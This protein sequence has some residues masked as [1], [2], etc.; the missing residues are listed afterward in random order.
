MHARKASR[1]LAHIGNTE[2]SATVISAKVIWRQPQSSWSALSAWYCHA[3]DWVHRVKWGALTCI[4]MPPSSTKSKSIFKL[5]QLRRGQTLC[6]RALWQTL[7]GNVKGQS[8]ATG[9][10]KFIP[11]QEQKAREEGQTIEKAKET[12]SIYAMDQ[13]TVL[14]GGVLSLYTV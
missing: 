12:L 10:R 13:K 11:D 5:R 3:N 14:K 1:S 9:M 4:T 2:A 8:Q 7:H 6:G